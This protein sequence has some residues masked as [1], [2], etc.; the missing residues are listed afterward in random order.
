MKS[1]PI[2]AVA[3]LAILALNIVELNAQTLSYQYSIPQSVTEIDVTRYLGFFDSNL[4]TLTGATLTFDSAMITQFTLENTA[5]QTQVA[6]FTTEMFYLW[7]SS[8]SA[9]QSVFSGEG[10]GSMV[11]GGSYE[12]GI[13]ARNPGQVFSYGPFTLNRQVEIDLVDYLSLFQQAGGGEFDVRTRTAVSNTHIGG[14]GNVQ[15]VQNTTAGGSA[16]IV[17]TYIPVP[18]ASSA[19]MGMMACGFGLLRRRR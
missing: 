7:S 11:S 15:V 2:S 4:G 13:S 5:A 17:Y 14:G 3:G 1:S 9:I 10:L 8:S 18:E 16:T 19:I 12:T 6:G